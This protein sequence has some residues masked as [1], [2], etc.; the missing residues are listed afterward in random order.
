MQEY[1]GNTQVLINFCIKKLVTITTLKND[2]EVRG[3]NKLYNE[4]E[5]SVTNLRTLNVLDLWL[6]ISSPTEKLSPDLRLRL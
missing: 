3:L 2:R 6:S 4:V 1:Y 5:T